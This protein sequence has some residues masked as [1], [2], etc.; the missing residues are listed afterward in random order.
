[1]LLI[2]I[3]ALP[4]LLV[5]KNID[6]ANILVASPVSG[7][8]H[9][10][11]FEP[12]FFK[13][14]DRGH[15]LTVISVYQIKEKLQNYTIITPDK[16]LLGSKYKKFSIT[17]FIFFF[18]WRQKD[19]QSKIIEK[20]PGKVNNLTTSEFFKIHNKKVLHVT[21]IPKIYSFTWVHEDFATKYWI[22]LNEASIK[23]V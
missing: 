21:T 17:N 19:Y 15:N 12:L 2:L 10:K 1:M 23:L 3:F 20:K 5:F 8:S 9:F 16:K 22:K 7:Y 11:P 6:G 4:A 13:L 14:R 18:F